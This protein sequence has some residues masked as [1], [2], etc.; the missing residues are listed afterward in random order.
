M[1][2]L[3][4]GVWC[5]YM[6]TVKME[7]SMDQSLWEDVCFDAV[8]IY[9]RLER[10]EKLERHRQIEE[11]IACDGDMPLKDNRYREGRKRCHK[12]SRSNK[13]KV[14]RNPLCRRQK[15]Y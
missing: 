13:R 6:Q 10:Q 9:E 11:Q 1:G 5:S 7:D 15:K 4:W 14:P 3:E 2:S 12:Q 8:L